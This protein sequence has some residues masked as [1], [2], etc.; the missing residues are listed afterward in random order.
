MA[1]QAKR[2][3]KAV[4]Q[5]PHLSNGN[6]FHNTVPRL[7]GDPLENHPLASIAGSHRNDPHWA[8]YV[9]VMKELRREELERDMKNLENE[10]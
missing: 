9:Q 7:P 3:T 8:E 1:Q 5:A 10:A 4:P 6:G 2:R